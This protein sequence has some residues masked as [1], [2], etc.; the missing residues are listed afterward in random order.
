MAT[1]IIS[2]V[3]KYVCNVKLTRLIYFSLLQINKKKKK[4]QYIFFP[5]EISVQYMIRIILNLFIVTS[6]QSDVTSLTVVTKGNQCMYFSHMIHPPPLIALPGSWWYFTCVSVCL[7]V[8]N[9]VI[10]VLCCV[11]P[12]DERWLGSEFV[13]GCSCLA[14]ASTL[15]WSHELMP[16]RHGYILVYRVSQHWP[17]NLEYLNDRGGKRKRGCF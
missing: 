15:K 14:R 5:R 4:K 13:G 17:S 2:T 1:K 3:Q 6:I 10:R 16:T 7:Y 8:P 9:I 11:Q 12:L